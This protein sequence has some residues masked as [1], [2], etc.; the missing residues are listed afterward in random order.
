MVIISCAFPGCD[1]R[2]EDVTE[3]IACAL[4]QS[5]A[6]IHSGASAVHQ[7]DEPTQARECPGPK[8]ERPCIDIGVSM[9]DWNVF[10]RRWRVFKEGSGISD[11]AAPPQLFQCTSKALGD[12]LLNFDADITTKPL[13]E[14]TES[15]RRLAV[16]P[17]ATVILRTELMQMRQM[18]DESFRSFSA[19]VRGKA[20]TY[21]F[22]AE[23][24]CGL[25]VYYTDHMIR[26]TLLNG[27]SDSDICREVL[28]TADILTMAIN[29]VI[30]LVESK[31][32]ARNAMPTPDVSA[33]S[34]FRRQLATPPNEDC[35]P[36]SSRHP[37]LVMT[38][39]SKRSPCPICKQP[40]P[41]YREGP[42]G[43]NTKP[44]T[45]CIDCFRT[46]RRNQRRKPPPP[47]S[48]AIT[49]CSR[50]LDETGHLGAIMTTPPSPLEEQ[51]EISL[52]ESRR[53][54]YAHY[55]YQDGHWTK[56]GMRAHP[57]IAVCVSMDKSWCRTRHGPIVA[58]NVPAIADT[59]A[60]TNVWSLRHFL[61][62]G[63]D[64]STLIPA[65]DLVA[66]NHSGINII[67]AFFAVIKGLDANKT[68]VQCHAMIYVSADISHLYLSQAT[69]ADLGVLSPQFPLIGEHPPLE[70]HNQDCVTQLPT[71]PLRSMFGGCSSLSQPTD[72]CTCPQRIT[73]PPPPSSLPFPCTP[74]NNAKMRAWLLDRYAASTFNTCP[75]RPLHCMA[76]PPIEIHVDPL[77]KPV[78]CHTPA[79]IPLH[80]QQ[81][82][83]DDLL[84]DKAMGILE[85][86]PHGEP[87]QWCH[88]MVITRKHDGSPRR[89][90]DLSPLNKFCKHET[91]A[92]EAPFHL[93]RRVPRNTW[94]TV[95]D[96]WNGYHSVPLQD[97]DRHLTTFITPFG[98]WRYTRAPQGFLS[99]GDGYNRRFSAIIADF[100]RKERCV[101]DTIFYDDSLQQH[102]WRTIEFLTLVGRQVSSSILKS[103]SLLNV[104]L[105]LLVFVSPN[106]L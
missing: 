49:D 7:R 78:A 15:I 56:A 35:R 103:S 53:S 100:V 21:A 14:I 90:V 74:E 76:G 92:F 82:V 3:A 24:S 29:D 51:A 34:A 39:P 59:G 25:R 17:I 22:F 104:R 18:R 2:S 72:T 38:S 63:F 4:L 61:A 65:S 6:F 36:S 71:T 94:K 10:L 26:D 31:E 91:H 77:A 85:K 41:V 69:L 33:V 55:V 48:S 32:M 81:K 45:L 106:R 47:T 44:F 27:I 9:E 105:T 66:A 30:A 20:D 42:R 87:T 83:H 52:Q 101:D 62:A 84:R 43:W 1:F 73:V 50:T 86:V 8:L 89:T 28:G 11:T 46:R 23:C 13:D 68:E 40:F 97:S 67:G 60:Q 16:V 19:R 102:W 12:N 98:K 95:T 96:A 64:R 37:S 79:T 93:A 5:H 75:H 99:S 88:R 54:D 80:W 57:V 58:R 70:T